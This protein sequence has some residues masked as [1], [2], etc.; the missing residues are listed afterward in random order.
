MQGNQYLA[1]V[2]VDEP[3]DTYQRDKFHVVFRAEKGKISLQLDFNL[4][5]QAQAETK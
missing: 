2:A 3:Q 4:C 5:E 1:L